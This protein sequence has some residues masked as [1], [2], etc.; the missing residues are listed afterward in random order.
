MC[1]RPAIY[2]NQK[3][4]ALFLYCFPFLSCWAMSKTLASVNKELKKKLKYV[5]SFYCIFL[6]S[7]RKNGKC[8]MVV[9]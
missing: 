7:H 1:R 9:C 5:G 3:F 6:I 8:T 4:I 2:I